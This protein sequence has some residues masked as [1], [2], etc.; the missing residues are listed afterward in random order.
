MIRKPGKPRIGFKPSVRE[1]QERS[2]S[3]QSFYAL[4]SGM[5]RPEFHPLAPKK[6]RAKAG[7]DGRILESDVQKQIIDYLR[8]HPKV[9]V[10]ERANSG[11]AYNANG[12]P[13]RFNTVYATGVRKVDLDIQLKSGI[14]LVVECK[15]PG[16][17][18]P[19]NTREEEQ[20]AYIE[21]I[22]SGGGR[23]CF[24]TCIDDVIPYLV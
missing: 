21:L 7:S 19:T 13:V 8:Q 15:R 9:C 20:A 4:M 17:T 5:P 16:W 24:A 2:E 23:G 10:V 14:R 1:L 3:A 12:A 22:K 18:K 11:V 6:T